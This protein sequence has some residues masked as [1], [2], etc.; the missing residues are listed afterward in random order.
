MKRI[1]EITIRPDA[2]PRSLTL[3]STASKRQNFIGRLVTDGRLEE[4]AHPYKASRKINLH[5]GDIV[6]TPNAAASIPDVEMQ[7]FLSRHASGDWGE[8]DSEG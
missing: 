7:A 3:K 6:M 4:S 1:L 8:V 2:R 5:L